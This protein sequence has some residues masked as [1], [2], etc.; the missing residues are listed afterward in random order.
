MKLLLRWNFHPTFV[1]TFSPFV[2][3]R[4]A[5]ARTTATLSHAASRQKKISPDAPYI[6]GGAHVVK[7]LVLLHLGHSSRMLFEVLKVCVCM[8]AKQSHSCPARCNE[9]IDVD[10]FPET[11]PVTAKTGTISSFREDSLLPT[12]SSYRS[13]LG[14][15]RW[16]AA[17]STTSY[18]LIWKKTET[19]ALLEE[20]TWARGGQRPSLHPFSMI[21]FVKPM[22]LD[23]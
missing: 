3:D 18:F 21:G 13:S 19:T 12:N 9:V 5:T 6:L 7:K 10:P 8:E 20:N 2:A 16:P 22:L 17:F 14:P 4:R 15:A 23:A 1:A 11:S